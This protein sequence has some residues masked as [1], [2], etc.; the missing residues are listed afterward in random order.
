MSQDI[1]FSQ[2]Y[3]DIIYENPSYTGKHNAS[4]RINLVNRD[5]WRSVS[6]PYKTFY[7][8]FDFG[9]DSTT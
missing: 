7:F 9:C 8:G 4:T 3:N 5:Q 2:V 6:I 1:H